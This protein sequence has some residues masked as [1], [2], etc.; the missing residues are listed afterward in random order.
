MTKQEIEAVL[1]LGL[2]AGASSLSVRE[3]LALVKPPVEALYEEA[4]KQTGEAFKVL[5]AIDDYNAPTKVA[6]ETLT[7]SLSAA[8]YAALL[9]AGDDLTSR[10][11]ETVVQ[12]ALFHDAGKGDINKDILFKPGRLTREDFETVKEHTANGPLA[13]GGFATIRPEIPVASL[14]HHWSTKG[15]GPGADESYLPR[16][17]TG[18]VAGNGFQRHLVDIVSIA[19]SISAVVDRRTYSD[20]GLHRLPAILNE[21][22]DM[23]DGGSY[24]R[25]CKGNI[26]RLG[27]TLGVSVG[28]RTLHGRGN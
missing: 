22:W 6:R 4:E 7:H 11:K 13:L 28:E 1:V 23:C 27:D 10:Q 2:E 14:Y 3:R 8:V 5:L 12:A 25:R 26:E 18:Y 24:K 21:L 19:D 20:G 15:Y 17:L 9:V 16:Y